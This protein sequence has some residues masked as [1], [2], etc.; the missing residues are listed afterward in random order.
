MF[1]SGIGS[2]V[3]LLV[4]STFSSGCC[5]FTET[6]TDDMTLLSSHFDLL[7]LSSLPSRL[8]LFSLLVSFSFPRQMMSS[9][10]PSACF[11]KLFIAFPLLW[12][13]SGGSCLPLPDFVGQILLMSAIRKA[14]K[15]WL[16]PAFDF[17]AG[18]AI[19]VLLKWSPSNIEIYQTQATQWLTKLSASYRKSE[20][21][22]PRANQSRRTSCSIITV[23]RRKHNQKYSHFSFHL[24]HAYR[25]S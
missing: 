6:F 5:V 16:R 4:S 25:R 13:D 1:S 14:E 19:P 11:W 9:W 8:W 24:A 3:S 15:A 17:F 7:W 2:P 12:Y 21:Q 10:L 20:K 22:L 18:R 23:V